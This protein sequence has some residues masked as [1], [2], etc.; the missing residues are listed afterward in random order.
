MHPGSLQFDDIHEQCSKAVLPGHALLLT[1]HIINHTIDV[2]VK[3]EKVCTITMYKMTCHV[4]I[5]RMTLVV[6]VGRQYQ[7]RRNN[8]LLLL[9]NYTH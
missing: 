8:G 4:I 6:M 9:I 7:L 2:D 5:H 1:M 3:D